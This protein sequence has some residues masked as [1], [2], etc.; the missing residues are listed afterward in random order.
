MGTLM[1]DIRYALRQLK[2]PWVCG[3]SYCDPG[4]G[5]RRQHCHFQ[6]DRLDS[7]GAAAFPHQD[8]LVQVIAD[9]NA[10]NSPKGWIREYQR[11][12]HAMASVAAIP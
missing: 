10:S 7:S 1:Q 3:R 6:R 8:R 4:A 9:P 11:R 12:S 2:E 5:N